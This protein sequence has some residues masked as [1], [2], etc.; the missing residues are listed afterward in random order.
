MNDLSNDKPMITFNADAN[1]W[2]LKLTKDGI[3]FNKELY[4]NSQPDD[5]AQAFIDLLEK[6]FTIKFERTEPPYDRDEE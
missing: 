2:F 1:V 3:F 6:K 5:F 4:P